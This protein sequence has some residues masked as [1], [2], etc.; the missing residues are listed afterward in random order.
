[1]KNMIIDNYLKVVQTKYDKSFILFYNCNSI[2]LTFRQLLVLCPH[3]RSKFPTGV[4]S[5]QHGVTSNQQDDS[6]ALTAF[7]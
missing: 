1:M 4:T 3:Y 5:N 6:L 7:F 2:I